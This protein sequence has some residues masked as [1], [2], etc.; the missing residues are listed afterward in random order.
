MRALKLVGIS[1]SIVG[2]K[3]AVATNKVL[4]AAKA[5]NHNIQTEFIDLRDYDVELVRGW[6]LVSYN[7]DTWDVVKKIQEA[8][9]LIFGSPIY[10]ASI[11]GVLKN[12]L[13][14]MPMDAF[15]GKVTGMLTTGGSEKHYLVA[16]YHLKPI[17]SYLK[18]LVPSGNVFVHNDSYDVDNEI[19]DDDVLKRIQRL[20][21]EILN[22]QGSLTKGDD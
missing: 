11:S 15:K 5:I 9:A 13:D 16:E 12:L 21:Q 18:G 2:E 3:T 6:A 1:G 17:L 7:K 8:D 10:Q 19:I 20:A 22:L 4:E 14:H